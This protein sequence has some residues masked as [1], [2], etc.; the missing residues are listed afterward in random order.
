M[1]PVTVWVPV[2]ETVPVRLHSGSLQVPGPQVR[3]AR[4]LQVL[5]RTL[6][7]AQQQPQQQPLEATTRHDPEAAPS[8]ADSGGS[9]VLGYAGVGEVG[10]ASSVAAASTVPCF[11]SAVIPMSPSGGASQDTAR[12][13]ATLGEER[14]QTFLRLPTQDGPLSPG[15]PRRSLVYTPGSSNSLVSISSVA[16]PLRSPAGPQSPTSRTV[17]ATSSSWVAGPRSSN[18]H[19]TRIGPLELYMQQVGRLPCNPDQLRAFVLN[20][21]GQISYSL[22]KRLVPPDAALSRRPPSPVNRRRDE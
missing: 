19:E 21:G 16:T 6:P 1:R 7:P 8:P 4:G 14:H 9:V 12:V 15:T 20:R 3:V 5:V 22:A 2:T 18:G 17:K 13:P 11:K 10:T